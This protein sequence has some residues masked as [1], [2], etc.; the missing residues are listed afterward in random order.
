MPRVVGA[1]GVVGDSEAGECF[2]AAADY[3]YGWL[4]LGTVINGQP[5]A[6]GA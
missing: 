2:D 4:W 1:V 5:A 6:I 3:S